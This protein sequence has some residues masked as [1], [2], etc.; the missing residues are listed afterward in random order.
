MSHDPLLKQDLALALARAL[1]NE[2]RVP[3]EMPA[4]AA[5]VRLQQADKVVDPTELGGKLLKELDRL[6]YTVERQR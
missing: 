5:H 6:G 2:I 3:R 1:V 4:Q